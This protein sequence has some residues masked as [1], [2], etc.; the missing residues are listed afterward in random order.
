M[1]GEHEKDSSY[2]HHKGGVGKSTAVINVGAALA[3]LRYHALLV[4]TD[5]QGHTT[6]AQ[7]IMVFLLMSDGY[8]MYFECI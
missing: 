6:R 4:D 1:W 3:K 2:K 7:A 5:A 8:S